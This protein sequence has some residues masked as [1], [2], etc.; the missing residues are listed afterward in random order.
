MAYY[1]LP[2]GRCLHRT[3]G[4]TVWGVDPD[5]DVE[6]TPRQTNRWAEIRKETDLLKTMQEDQLN[7]L[8]EQ[9]LQNDLQLQT[10]LLLLKLELLAHG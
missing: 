1:Y 4:S 7:S 5:V 3:N 8:L 2:H 10:S 9:Q 6:V